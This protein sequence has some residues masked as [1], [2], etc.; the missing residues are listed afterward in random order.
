MQYENGIGYDASFELNEYN[1]PKLKSEVELIRDTLL[2]ILF[3]A[4]GSYPSLPNIG[5]DMSANLYTLYEDLDVEDLQSQIVAQCA[6]LGVY[7]SS[8]MIRIKK[9]KYNGEPSLIISVNGD[10]TYPNGYLSDSHNSNFL[11][12]I[13]YD[14]AKQMMYSIATV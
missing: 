10:A 9:G 7:F 8:D 5:M 1:Q 14:K 4:P 13:T 11:V 6:A 2:F 3:A 12:G